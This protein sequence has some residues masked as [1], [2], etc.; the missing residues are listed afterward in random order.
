MASCDHSIARTPREHRLLRHFRSLS[1]S[2]QS[3]VLGTARAWA[4][5]PRLDE[6]LAVMQVGGRAVLVDLIRNPEPGENVVALVPQFGARDQQLQ[7]F[8][9][10]GRTVACEAI[11]VVVQGG[12]AHG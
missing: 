4:D 1:P 5:R 3:D 12:P 2:D 11:G 6:N 9:A 7:A 10:Q 8:T